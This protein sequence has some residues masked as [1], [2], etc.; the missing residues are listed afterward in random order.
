MII[1][2]ARIL[3]AYATRNGSTAEIALAVAKELENAGA[4]VTVSDM[5]T[6]TSVAD[7]TA[8]VIGAPLYMGNLVKEVKQ[9]V[10]RHKESLQKRPIAVFAVGIAPK[11]PDPGAVG[12]ATAALHVAIDPLQP[13]ASIIFA[14]K[15]DTKKLSFIQRKMTELAKSPVGDF[16]DW[17]AIAAWAR[18]LTG[19][20][21]IQ[22]P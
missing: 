6:I 5:K 18:E 22:L 4:A 9:F 2:T 11:S 19:K 17:A 3:V 16:R 10:G 20:M 8:V 7:Y 12:Q 13:V 1:M 21:S 15:V 14:G